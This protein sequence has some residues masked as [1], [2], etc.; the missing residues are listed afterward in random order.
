MVTAI[1]GLTHSKR[2]QSAPERIYATQ[3]MQVFFFASKKFIYLS[4]A[5]CMRKCVAI[6]CLPLDL[7]VSIDAMLKTEVRKMYKKR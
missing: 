7:C 6:R 4:A 2:R 3:N 5:A 1:G